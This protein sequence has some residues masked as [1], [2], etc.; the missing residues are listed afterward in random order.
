MYVSFWQTL[1]NCLCTY[2][3]FTNLIYSY[4]YTFNL[5]FYLHGFT[6]V[7]QSTFAIWLPQLYSHLAI[8]VTLG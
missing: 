5:V 6:C 2:N 8:K 3:Q 4:F 7:M 1:L